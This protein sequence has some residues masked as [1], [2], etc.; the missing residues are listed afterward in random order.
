[1]PATAPH[2]DKSFSHGPHII[3][4]VL[5]FGGW[6]G[7]WIWR[8]TMHK[9]DRNRE[10]LFEIAQAIESRSLRDRTREERDD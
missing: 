2:Q 9:I 10:A 6:A 4:T 8:L 1:M 3:G 7:I 5:T